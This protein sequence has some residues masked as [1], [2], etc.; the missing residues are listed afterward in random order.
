MCWSHWLWARLQQHGLGL[1]GTPNINQHTAI[2]AVLHLKNNW[3]LNIAGMYRDQF[4]LREQQCDGHV[5]SHAF[6]WKRPWALLLQTL[7]CGSTTRLVQ[8]PVLGWRWA[9]NTNRHSRLSWNT[10]A[11]DLTHWIIKLSDDLCFFKR[12]NVLFW[13]L[14]N[15]KWLT[16][17]MLWYYNFNCWNEPGVLVSSCV[18]SSLLSQQHY[19]LQWRSGS[20]G[21]WRGKRYTSTS[22]EVTVFSLS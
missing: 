3:I 14:K 21:K 8:N 2:T 16:Y 15:L 7:G 6:H 1:P 17:V 12:V 11:S 19:F 18:H 20:M 13:Y 22:C 10:T 5:S 9:L 4:V